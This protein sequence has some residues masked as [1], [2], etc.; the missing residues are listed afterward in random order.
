[1]PVSLSAAAGFTSAVTELKQLGWRPEMQV[2]EIGSPQRIAPYS[3][4]MAAELVVH[5][6]PVAQGRIILLHDPAG[7]D[8]WDGTFRVVTYTKAS[9]DIEMATDPMLPDVTWTWMQDALA[10]RGAEHHELAGTVT[11]SYGKGFGAMAGSQDR[12]EVEIRAS[13]TPSSSHEIGLHFLAWEDL[14]GSVSGHPNLPQ[15]VVALPPRRT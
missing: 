7:N 5:G 6:Q 9:I 14:L 10:D 3:L 1:M 4:A 11:A 8:A 13:W 2:S 15:G 12:A